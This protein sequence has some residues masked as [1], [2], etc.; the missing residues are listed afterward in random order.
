M[1]VRYSDDFRKSA[2]KLAKRYKNL[3]NDLKIFTNSLIDNP[4]QGTELFMNV[5][6]VRIKNSDNDKGKSAGYRMIT[7]LIT[8]DKILLVNMYSKSDI[9]NV[10]DEDINMIIKQ[11]KEEN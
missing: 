7:Y 10:S 2:K 4:R 11:Y 8:E 9:S 1:E 3:K 6:K 5:Y